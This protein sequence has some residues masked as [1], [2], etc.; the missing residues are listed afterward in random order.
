M[1]VEHDENGSVSR[2]SL[3]SKFGE[4]SYGARPYPAWVFREAGGGGAVTLPFVRNPQ[5]EILVGLLLE[6]RPNMGGLRWCAVGGFI[7]PNETHMETGLRETMEETGMAVPPIFELDGMAMNPNRQFFDADPEKGEGVRTF[8]M[9]LPA[10]WMVPNGDGSFRIK[11]GIQVG[12][13]NPE[14]LAFFPVRDAIRKTGD[15]LA[16]GALAKLWA[17]A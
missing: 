5:G 9:E 8:G 2:M 10:D 11:E 7:D 14:R 3:S 13:K 16:L 1:S 6:D 15:A 17:S 12:V 4:L